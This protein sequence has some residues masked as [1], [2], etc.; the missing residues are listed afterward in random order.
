MSPTT[1][2][3]SV[4]LMIVLIVIVDSDDVG[5]MGWSAIMSVKGVEKWTLH[6]ALGGTCAEHCSGRGIGA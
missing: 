2:V 4:N 1:V 5:R 6:T 3:S